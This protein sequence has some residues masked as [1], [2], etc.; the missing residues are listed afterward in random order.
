MQNLRY[1]AF[2]LLLLLVGCNQRMTYQLE[3]H[4]MMK[5]DSAVGVDTA[6][7]SFIKP[8][9]DSIQGIMTDVIGIN[10]K[11]LFA[12]KPESELSNFVVDLVFDAGKEYLK[13]QN[14]PED[15]ILCVINI[16]GLR[17]PLPQG[18]L[19]TRNIFEIMPFENQMVGV[20]MD[21]ENLKTLFDHIAKSNGDGI[22]GASFTLIENE[23]K[24]ILINGKPIDNE[25]TYWVITS[26]YLASGGDS[27]TVF[28]NSA[29]R[30]NFD[31]KI[32]ELIIKHIRNLTKQNREII[33]DMTP[34]IS[35]EKKN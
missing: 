16:R 26:D 12:K 22:A 10:P 5:I 4:N 33:P 24:N 29:T 25:K 28:I 7:L 14:I 18:E 15:E 32:R 20:K 8:Y 31:E 11:T 27:Y 17:A 1:I 9:H 34:R 35:V 19:T 3:N 30:L 2:G 13:K 23:A 21:A 6:L